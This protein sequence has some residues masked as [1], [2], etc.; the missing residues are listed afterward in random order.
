[1]I[2]YTYD[3]N[4]QMTCQAQVLAVSRPQQQQEEDTSS[5][6]NVVLNTSVLHAQ[7]GGQPSDHGTIAPAEQE[8]SD[9]LVHIDKVLIDRTT[10]VA[11]H[12]GTCTSPDTLLQVGEDVCVAVQQ[13]RRRLLSECHTAGHVCDA[14]MAKCGQT[15]K[16][17]KAYHYLEGPY[18]E[19]QGKID[20]DREQLLSNLQQAFAQLV[21]ENVDTTIEL[22]PKDQAIEVCNRTAE[23]FDLSGY[24][25]QKNVRVVTVAGW[26]CPCGG[27]HVASTGELIENK[28]GITGIKTKKGVVRIKYGQN[29]P[30]VP[31]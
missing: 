8:S 5:R 9:R 25:Q 21:S 4:F 7:G 15:W 2:Y 14:A 11:T 3:G 12:S 26:P 23:N 31:Q 16:P 19:Y 24:P 6:V 18:V 20:G 30:V 29:A 27:T 13:D 17:T 10:G 1:M 22:L 28:W